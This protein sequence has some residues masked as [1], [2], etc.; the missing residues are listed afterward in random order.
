MK[1]TT[2]AAVSTPRGKG[3]VAVIR[4]SG[5]ETEEILDRCFVHVGGKKTALRAARTACYGDLVLGDEVIDRVLCTFFRAPHS[6]TGEDMA[7]ISCH[8]GV[9]VTAAALRAVF[10]AGAIPAQRGEFTKRAYL[11]GKLSL[12]EADAVGTLIDAD[13]E[14]RRKLSSEISRGSLRH[15][16]ERIADRLSDHLTMLYAAIDYP[17][18]EVGEEGFT[19]LAE[20]LRTCREETEK[21]LATYKAGSA[22]ISGVETVICGAPNAGKSTLYNCLLGEERAIVTDVPGTTRDLLDATAE[23]AGITLR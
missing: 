1:G 6:Y 8:G 14:T 2:I 12:S 19:R 23:I 22:V 15:A 17:E 11:A 7:E 16:V 10:H 3:G 18:E 13:T 21:L 9:S 20:T 4:I 5:L